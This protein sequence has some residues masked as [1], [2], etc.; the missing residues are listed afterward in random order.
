[1]ETASALA[2]VFDGQAHRTLER[3][4]R[5]VRRQTYLTDAG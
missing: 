2:I 5:D 4:L 1:M 3:A